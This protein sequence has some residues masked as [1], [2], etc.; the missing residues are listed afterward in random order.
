MEAALQRQ[1]GMSKFIVSRSWL[2]W[3]NFF[4]QEQ[5]LRAV[6]SSIAKPSVSLTRHFLALHRIKVYDYDLVSQLV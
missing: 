3:K 6:L 2:T 4:N 1:K 5:Y